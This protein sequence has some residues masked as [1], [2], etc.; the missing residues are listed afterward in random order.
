MNVTGHTAEQ[1]IFATFAY[2]L[3]F[4]QPTNGTLAVLSAGNPLSSGD[5]IRGG[6]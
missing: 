4:N 6:H 1:S 2:T 3:N 5:I